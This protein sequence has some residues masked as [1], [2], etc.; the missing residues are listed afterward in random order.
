MLLLLIV[1]T[2]NVLFGVGMV[3]MPLS[4]N[5]PHI[6]HGWAQVVRLRHLYA[7]RPG[8]HLLISEG[9]QIRGSAVQTLHSL[10][11]I[12][13]VGPGRVAIRG[14]ATARFLCI[15]DDGT[16]YSS[17]ACSREDCIF[18]EQILPDGYNIYIS[19]RHGVLLSLGN[20]RQRLQ[21][22]DRGDPALAQFLPRISTLNQIPSPGAKIGDHMKEAKTEEPVDTIDSFGKFSQIIDSPSFHK[23]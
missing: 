21:G 12:R 2:V 13:P 7:T 23:R 6:A 3:C 10:M 8:M 4:D 5:G 19:D 1:S 20:H 17:H 11:E 16:L 22:L 9:G 14:V 15:E 18:R